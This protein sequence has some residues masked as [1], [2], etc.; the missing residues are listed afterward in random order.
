M[1]ALNCECECGWLSSD[2]RLAMGW[3]FALGVP[4]LAPE[5]GWDRFRQPR[6]RVPVMNAS[7]TVLSGHNCLQC[8]RP[9][10][11]K[12]Y[13]VFAEM[14]FPPIIRSC[15]IQIQLM[16]SLNVHVPHVSNAPLT[17]ARLRQPRGPG[18]SGSLPWTA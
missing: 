11:I 8:C 3:R 17:C 5:D 2:G 18:W 14:E 9:F 12:A 15:N 4:P 1:G 10:A 6:N 13:C 7:A 16:C